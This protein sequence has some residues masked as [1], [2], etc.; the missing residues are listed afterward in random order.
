MQR[1]AKSAR[2]M[3]AVASNAAVG[4]YTTSRHFPVTLCS[5]WLKQLHHS[6][7]N[8]PIFGIR[9]FNLST[10]QPLNWAK[11]RTHR[12]ARLRPLR[13]DKVWSHPNLLSTFQL[14]PECCRIVA[15]ACTTI[16]AQ[17]KLT[18][19]PSS[20]EPTGRT[21][22]RSGSCCWF[23][24]HWR[25]LSPNGSQRPSQATGIVAAGKPTK[26]NELDEIG[27]ALA[28]FINATA[29]EDSGR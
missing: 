6:T 18:P 28:K 27:A 17:P 29:E 1:N 25:H 14:F 4:G 8:P 2:K 13:S 16:S 12:P 20:W 22:P 5:L 21:R 23:V 19:R 11:P 10:F 7:S 3:A 24:R 9:L 15:A 26:V